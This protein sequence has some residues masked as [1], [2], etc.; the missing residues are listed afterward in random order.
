VSSNGPD[1]PNEFLAA[2]LAYAARGWPVFPVRPGRKEPLTRKGF[3]N[4]TTDPHRIARWWQKWPEANVGIATGGNGPLVV[5]VD[6]PAG[7]A[8]AANLELPATL[9]ATTGRSDGG[10]HLY[11]SDTTG[12]TRCDHSG[13]VHIK[14]LGGYVVAPPSVHPSGARYRWAG[15]SWQADPLADAP[16]WAL[17]TAPA[18][19]D[20]PAPPPATPPPILETTRNVTLTAIAGGLRTDGLTC[21]ELTA[22]L[23]GVNAERCR[24]PLPERE[25]RAIAKSVSRYP[26]APGGATVRIPKAIL[27][28]DLSPGALALYA[29]RQALAQLTGRRPRQAALAETLGAGLRTV[30][31][32]AAELRRADL[33]EYQ[34]PRGK[35]LRAP[36]QLLTDP[37]LTVEKKATALHL[38]ALT[39]RDGM[40]A[41]GQAAL[42]ETTGRDPGTVKRHLRALRNGGYITAMVAAFDPALGRRQR[43]NRYAVVTAGAQQPQALVPKKVPLATHSAQRRHTRAVQK[44]PL[45]THESR[46]Y[47]CAIN[48]APLDVSIR[49]PHPTRRDGPRAAQPSP[50]PLAV[51]VNRPQANAVPVAARAAT[52]AVSSNGGPRA[53]VGIHGSGGS[54]VTEATGPPG[55]GDSEP[56][57]TE[58]ARVLAALRGLQVV[59]V[60]TLIQRHG[61][62]AATLALSGKVA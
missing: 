42:A 7:E 49:I 8:E 40:A 58:A 57:V 55:G 33:G 17:A 34:R 27:A 9:T 11:Y 53:A 1:A 16:A 31:R 51:A 30:K 15:P 19:T 52:P 39:D 45:A 54:G 5:D 50:L 18:S 47:T 41:V 48:S 2:A 36:A 13:K 24:P 59:Y 20:E 10:R 4:A 62:A 61:L 22:A 37:A 29:T 43:T 3:K 25:V 12:Q 28:R 38:C 26:A 32:W 14:G 21:A 46:P 60:A 44:G 56:E 6:G 23:L 35:Y